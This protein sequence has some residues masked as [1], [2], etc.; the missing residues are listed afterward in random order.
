MDLL[1]EQLLPLL[2][3]ALP[4]LFLAECVYCYMQPEESKNIMSWFGQKMRA[5]GCVGI[6][7]EMCGLE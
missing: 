1:T 5:G 6:L 3:S 7:Y 4:T 2:D